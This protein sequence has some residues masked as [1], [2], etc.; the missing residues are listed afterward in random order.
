MLLGEG[1]TPLESFVVISVHAVIW[2]VKETQIRKTHFKH[3]RQK[4]E[5]PKTVTVSWTAGIIKGVTAE[6]QPVSTETLSVRLPE[7][8]QQVGLINCE[9]VRFCRTTD[10]LWFHLQCLQASVQ[11]TCP[12]GAAPRPTLTFDPAVEGVQEC[13]QRAPLQESIK[14]LRTFL[15]QQSRGPLSRTARDVKWG[16]LILA[17]AH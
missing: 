8:R 17:R 2:R 10:R 14:K 7:R 13:K 6:K 12:R 11:L 4:S 15:L 1:N 9:S 3:W 16:N 5:E